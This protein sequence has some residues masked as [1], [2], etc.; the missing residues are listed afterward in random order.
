MDLTKYLLSLIEQLAVE[1]MK[2]TPDPDKLQNIKNT[3]N[4]LQNLIYLEV[5]DEPQP[6]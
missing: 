6:N 1:M 5:D 3:A 4:A 2:D